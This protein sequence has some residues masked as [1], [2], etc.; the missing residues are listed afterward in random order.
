MS[1][2]TQPEGYHAVTPYLICQNA[3]A[4]IEYYTQVFNAVEMSVMKHED[5]RVAHAELKIGD[6]VIML[7]DEAP[8]MGALSPHTVGGTPVSLLLYVPDVD[9]TFAK[10]IALGGTLERD[11]ATQFYG[12]RTGGLIDPS[13]H[14]WYLA[15]HVED[16]S[17]EEMRRR[18]EK[19]T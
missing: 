9:A 5:G 19:A 3:V 18:M 10:A 2:K 12:D 16:V 11:I 4:A 6:S 14:K 1:V 17:P 7:A 15:T 13:G 8:A